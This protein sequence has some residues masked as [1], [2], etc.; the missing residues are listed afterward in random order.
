MR[1][2]ALGLIALLLPFPARSL[3]LVPRPRLVCAEYFASQL[4][5]EATLI[6]V[7]NVLENGDP[8]A[9]LSRT[10]TLRVDQT[11]RG[12]QSETIQVSE[13]N[14]SGRAVFDWIPRRKY[15]LFL[16]HFGAERDWSLD[17]CGNSGPLRKSRR[18]L[19]VIEQLKTRHGDGFIHGVV[20]DEF[21]SRGISDVHV[22]ASGSAGVFTA[23]TNSKGRFEIKVPPGKYTV[24]ADKDADGETFETAELSY[25]DSKNIQIEPGECVQLQLSRVRR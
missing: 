5:V 8:Y 17:G 2:F 20:S 23:V 19:S 15:L 25:L 12:E 9:I 1:L 24:I 14:D 16:S 22:N 7:D 10:Y 13:S 18:A 6:H 11:L 21:L 3:C 4:V